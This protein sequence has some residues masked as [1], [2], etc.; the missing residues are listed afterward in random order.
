M[1]TCFKCSRRLPLDE[2]YRH[3]FMGDGRLGKCKPCTRKDVQENYMARRDQYL[4]YERSRYTPERIQGIAASK[5]RHPERDRA[6]K[7]VQNA[8]K[9]G[10]LVKSPCGDC[11]AVKV[12]GRHEDYSKPLE[13]IWLCRICHRKRHRMERVA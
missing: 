3:P 12:E 11:G 4:A 9:R 2:F 5:A 13:V 8:L 7:V 10:R 1:K 6:R